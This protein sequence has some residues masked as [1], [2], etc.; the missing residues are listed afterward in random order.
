MKASTTNTGRALAAL[1]LFLMLAVSVG[2]AQQKIGY[3]NS[4]KI[5]DELPS[6]KEAKDSLAGIVKIWQG[7]LDRMSKDLQEKYEDYQRKQGLYNDQTKQ[8]EQKKL[9]DEEQKMN[10]YKA[11]KFGQQ[12]ELAIQQERLMAP[13]KERIFAAIK[14]IATENKLAFVFDKAGDVVLLYGEPNA[15]YTYKVIDRLKRG[16]K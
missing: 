8:A 12:G 3:V 11:Q 15:D 6:A 13:I 1:V 2:G 10:D 14:Q 5:L 9:I 16:D 7:E 4:Q